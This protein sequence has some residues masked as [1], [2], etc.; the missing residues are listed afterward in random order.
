[1]T[2][3]P[4]D[5]I[6]RRTF[7]ALVA[8]GAREWIAAEV[9]RAVREAEAEGN[10]ICGLY[11]LESHCKQLRSGRVRGDVEPVVA[12]QGQSGSSHG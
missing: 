7:Q 5:E 9:A 12:R 11:Y 3:V 8:H 6:E 4:L 1:M 10:R 2:Q